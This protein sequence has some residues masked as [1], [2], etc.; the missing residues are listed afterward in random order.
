MVHKHCLHLPPFQAFARARS[1]VQGRG[2]AVCAG[3]DQQHDPGAHARHRA[4]LP[5][6]ARGQE[7]GRHR[8]RLLQRQ[9]A[10][11][12]LFCLDCTDGLCNPLAGPLG[13]WEESL[14]RSC[15]WSW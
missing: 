12:G 3:G 5:G 11:G 14:P 13:T 9:P 1:D 10:P 6:R 7:G 8:A 4:E 2:E 15:D